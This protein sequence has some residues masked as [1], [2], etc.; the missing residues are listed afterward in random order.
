MT[1]GVHA[2]SEPFQ[3]LRGAYY[4]PETH[5]TATLYESA[6]PRAGLRVPSSRKLAFYPVRRLFPVVKKTDAEPGTAATT[7]DGA[8]APNLAP[9]TVEMHKETAKAE[10]PTP[11]TFLAPVVEARIAEVTEVRVTTD[12]AEVATLSNWSPLELLSEFD[13]LTIFPNAMNPPMAAAATATTTE[14]APEASSP[15]MECE[16]GDRLPYTSEGDAVVAAVEPESAPEETTAAAVGDAAAT[17]R[18]WTGTG[19]TE[20]HEPGANAGEISVAEAAPAVK[21][22][23]SAATQSRATTVTRR[24]AVPSQLAREVVWCR[25]MRARFSDGAQPSWLQRSPEKRRE[26]V[27]PQIQ[28]KARPK[29]LRAFGKGAISAFTRK[30]HMP[31]Q[32]PRTRTKSNHL[33]R[34]AHRVS[35]KAAPA[36]SAHKRSSREAPTSGTA[37][38]QKGESSPDSNASLLQ[39][40]PGE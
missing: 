40:R 33:P 24:L 27:P 20:E 23:D 15:E 22:H 10:P 29:T 3:K 9:A 36:K 21:K 6:V 30:P 31:S 19:G 32:K 11:T 14:A 16:Q 38:G 8:A 34:T 18:E 12:E 37:P 35:S 28:L 17:R 7:S 4:S 13:N 39:G 2:M 5:S 25:A 1:R 26:I